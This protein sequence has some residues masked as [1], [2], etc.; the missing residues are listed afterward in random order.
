M[1]DQRFDDLTRRLANGTPGA[2]CSRRWPA[3]PSVGWLVRLVLAGQPLPHVQPM[4][5]VPVAQVV[6]QVSSGT[7]FRG[8]RDSR[9]HC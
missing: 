6:I 7:L 2:A 4:L 8:W 9:L 1:D 5:T 3:V